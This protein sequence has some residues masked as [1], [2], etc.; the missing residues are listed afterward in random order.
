MRENGAR[1]ASDGTI[2]AGKCSSFLVL[3]FLDSV[4]SRSSIALSRT[5][6]SLVLTESKRAVPNIC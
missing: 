3:V 2:F 4:M 1:Q 5:R 6:W